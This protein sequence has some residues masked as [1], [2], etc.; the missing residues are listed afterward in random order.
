M[1]K[2]VLREKGR[3]LMW[4]TLGM[5]EKRQRACREKKSHDLGHL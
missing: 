4:G 1:G 5:G 3:D 2:G